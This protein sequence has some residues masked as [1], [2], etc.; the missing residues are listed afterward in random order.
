MKTLRAKLRK[1]ID[2]LP[3][4]DAARRHH[5]VEY[6]LIHNK[7]RS[8]S[9]CTS[10][11]HFSL[12][13][14]ATQYVK[15]VLSQAASSLNISCAHLNGYAFHSDFPYLD[16]LSQKEFE[17]Y[18]YLFKPQGYLYSVF[19]GMIDGLQA[20]EK[21]LVVLMIRDPRDILVSSYYST[22]YSHPVPGKNSNKLAAFQEKRQE[23]Q[24]MKVDEYAI[25]ESEHLLEIY[26][27]YIELL[28]KQH[29]TCYVTKYEDMVENHEK[30]LNDLLAYCQLDIDNDLKARLLKQNKRLKPKTENI[31]DHMRKGVAGDFLEKLQPQT[32]GILNAKFA[33]ILERFAYDI[34]SSNI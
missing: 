16:L 25:N 21:Y 26:H 20:L 5:R 6:G 34:N 17:A 14:S 10:I 13:K 22:A 33:H 7:H 29:P 32:I 2:A 9:T 4:V 18:Q 8:K 23:T 12:N 27:R 1:S 31:N 30:W 15:K 28:L 11:L 3:F 19:G 24:Q